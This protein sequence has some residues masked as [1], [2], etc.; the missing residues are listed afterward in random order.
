MADFLAGYL[1]GVAGI[2]I[3]SPLDIIKTRT[4]SQVLPT[5]ISSWYQSPSSLLRGTYLIVGSVNPPSLT[6]SPD[7]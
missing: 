6:R 4:Q 7:S 2:I 3:G 1:S 5:G